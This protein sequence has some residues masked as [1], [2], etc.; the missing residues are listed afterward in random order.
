MSTEKGLRTYSTVMTVLF[1]LAL[2]GVIYLLFSKSKVQNAYETTSIE[3]DSLLVMRTNLENDL[4]TL[5]TDFQMALAENDSLSGSLSDMQQLVAEK[6]ALVKKIRAQ[7]A[8]TIDGLRREVNQL[9]QL[10]GELEGAFAKLQEE[11]TQLRA[12]NEQLTAENAQLT[13]TTG[14]LSSQVGDLEKFNKTLQNQVASLTRAGIKATAFRVDVERKSDKLTTSA[15]RTRGIN[16]AFD[17][18]DLPEEFQGTR[19]LYLVLTDINGLPLATSNAM[20]KANIPTP[21]GSTME[22]TAQQTKEVNLSKSQRLTFNYPVEEKLKAGTYV[23]T[24][25]ADFGIL[26]SA[27]FRLN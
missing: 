6:E 10:K 4:E 8:N 23:A 16:I 3:R 13:A 15:R 17:L 14:Q 11:N 20:T 21:N 5:S 9:R 19:T 24:V 25:Y 2:C 12:E 27:S 1:I 26:G 7:N 18:V 22:I